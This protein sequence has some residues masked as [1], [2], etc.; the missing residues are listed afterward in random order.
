M[1][2]FKPLEWKRTG[3][4]C[5]RAEPYLIMRLI[6][7]YIALHGPQTARETI[8][9]YPYTANTRL[10]AVAAAQAACEEHRALDADKV[11]A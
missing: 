1:E 6:T 7:K 10:E 8:G 3:K 9:E 2:I 11:R 4:L 5:L